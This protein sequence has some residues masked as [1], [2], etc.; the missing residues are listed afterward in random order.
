MPRD[1]SPREACSAR[2]CSGAIACCITFALLAVA[3]WPIDTK[4]A[5][6]VPVCPTAGA[7]TI[8]PTGALKDSKVVWAGT[9]SLRASLVTALSPLLVLTV[10]V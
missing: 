5:V 2:R 4:L 7:V 9:E 3:F 6:T 10:M 8:Q 1:G